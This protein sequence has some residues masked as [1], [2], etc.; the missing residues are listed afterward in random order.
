MLP[1]FDLL[2]PATLPEAL[3]MLSATPNALSLAGGTNLIPDLRKGMDA[4]GMLVDV[5]ELAELCCI[6]R[7]DGHLLIGGGVKIAELLGDPMI[8]QD[9]PILGEMARSFANA[10]I[11]N[12]ATIGGNLVNA[13]PCCDSAPVLLALNA[14]VELSSTAGKRCLPLAEFLVGAFSTKR[15]SNELLT[16]VRVPIPPKSSY[17]GFEKMGLR[18]V[19]CMAKVDVAVHVAVDDDT[20]CTSARIALGAVSPV[21]Y[22]AGASEEYLV[23]RALDDETIHEAARLAGASAQPRKGSEYKLQVVEALTKRLL[24]GVTDR[25]V[26]S[27]S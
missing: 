10:L 14:E 13:A 1:A 8:A 19:S 21:A 4:P 26:G 20:Q 18:K 11:R 2:R 12:R 7:K 24:A 23:G 3:Q 22:R 15:Q 6:R 25:I 17:G 16:C 9:A 5:S 27:E